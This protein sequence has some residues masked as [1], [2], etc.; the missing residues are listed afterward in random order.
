MPDFPLQKILLIQTAHIGDVVLA[1]PV[2]EALAE[3][4]PQAQLDVLIR[5]GNEE[6]FIHNPRIQQVLVWDKSNGKYV[7]LWHLLK[8][9]R[10]TQYDVVI[11]LHRHLSTG[12]L[13]VFSKAQERRGFDKNP[14]SF[15]FDRNFPHVIGTAGNPVHEVERNLSVLE[16]IATTSFRKPVLHFPARMDLPIDVQTPYLCVAPCSVWQTK[17]WPPEKWVQFLQKVPTSYTC[18]LLGG[19]ADRT[20]CERIRERVGRQEVVNLAG[21]VS[22]LQSAW[23]MKG[24]SMNFTHDSAPLHLA[25]AVNAPVA[26]VFCSTV[27]AFGFG[28]LSDVSFVVESSAQ[29]PCRPCGLHGHRRCPEG[30]FKCA[31]IPVEALLEKIP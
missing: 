1:T 17:A 3:A 26:A 29:L 10:R 24:A 2:L 8:E 20:V 16:G 5:K 30:H 14:L 27:P 6:F 13:T 9:I 7:G 4:H 23:L 28:P 22:L 18:Y 25:S 11:N 19:P 31:D 12:L 21:Q 15:L